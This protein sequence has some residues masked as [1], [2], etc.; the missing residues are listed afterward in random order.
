MSSKPFEGYLIE[1]DIFINIEDLF[2]ATRKS[3]FPAVQE[4]PFLYLSTTEEGSSPPPP[5]TSKSPGNNFR[6]DPFDFTSDGI[7]DHRPSKFRMDA[8]A[9][10]QEETM[11]Y[12]ELYNAFQARNTRVTVAVLRKV[13]LMIF[14]NPLCPI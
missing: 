3:S 13:R 12:A 7:E 6:I 2:H 1:V 10:S 5:P 14:K 11:L 9:F 4:K 8:N